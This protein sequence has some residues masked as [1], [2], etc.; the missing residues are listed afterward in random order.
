MT[1]TGGNGNRRLVPT[2]V[3]LNATL[4]ATSV[5]AGGAHTCAVISGGKE[6]CWGRN[7]EGQLGD[8]TNT[9]TA[10]PVDNGATTVVRVSAGFNHTCDAT[11]SGAVYCFGSNSSGQMGA[12]A[13]T[14]MRNTPRQVTGL[15]GVT[16]IAAGAATSCAINGSGQVMCWGKNDLGQLGNNTTAD[17]Y[18]VGTA[19]QGTGSGGATTPAV[20]L[21]QFTSNHI[22]LITNSNVA[23]C[24]GNGSMYQLGNGNNTSPRRTPVNVAGFP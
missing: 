6:F 17:T 16:A 23:R 11:S 13:A 2:A 21:S 5:S 8:G 15:F 4:V 1:Y 12:P 9:N 24:W 22:C 14:T 18:A 10:T 7:T 20:H 3:S 19:V